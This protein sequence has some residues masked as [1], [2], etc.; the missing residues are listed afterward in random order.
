MKHILFSLFFPAVIFSQNISTDNLKK[1]IAF[2]ASDNLHGRGT[3]SPDEKKAADYLAGEFKKTGLSPLKN[4]SYLREFTFKE[5]K[6]PHDTSSTG[7]IS[8]KGYNVEG[9]LDN[10]APLTVVIGAHFDHLGLGHDHN[11]L[12]ANPAGKIHNGADDNASGTAG[13]LELAHYFSTNNKPEK[14]NFLFICF[15]VGR[16]AW[17]IWF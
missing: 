1:H 5:K 16:R 8:R 10:K 13:V 15:S 14:F 3:S 2:L 7:S 9:F 4:N 17:L 12:D 11:S 6:S